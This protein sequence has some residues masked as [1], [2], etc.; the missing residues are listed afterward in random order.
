MILTKKAERS[1]TVKDFVNDW[2]AVQVLK[3][4]KQVKTKFDDEALMIPLQTPFGQFNWWP[5]PAAYNRL[6]DLLGADTDKWFNQTIGLERKLVKFKN[7]KESQQIVIDEEWAKGYMRP[8]DMR[9]EAVKEQK[10]EDERRMNDGK[11][12]MPTQE[13][14]DALRR[15]KEDQER[16]KREQAAQQM[17]G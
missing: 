3:G 16:L 14:I 15:Y 9:P 17:E 6:I 2:L 1:L 13:E 4:T 5:N 8:E 7:G 12:N 10:R 11:N